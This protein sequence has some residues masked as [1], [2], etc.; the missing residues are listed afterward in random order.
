MSAPN[1]IYGG[2][3]RRSAM[4][5]VDFY[6]RVPK[7]LTEV[8]ARC[9]NDFFCAAYLSSTF[10]RTAWRENEDVGSPVHTMVRGLLRDDHVG[11]GNSPRRR[12]DRIA[13]TIT[14]RVPVFEKELGWHVGIF[15]GILP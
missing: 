14:W 2:G 6:R 9:A 13:K 8:R 11:I 4:A 15:R 7:D 3:G 1:N 5:S 10:G 12:L